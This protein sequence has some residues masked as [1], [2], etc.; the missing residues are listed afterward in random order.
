MRRYLSPRTPYLSPHAK[1]EFEMKTVCL[2]GS[3][4]TDGNS[5]AIAGRFCETAE[6]LGSEVQTFV[7]NKLTYKGCQACKGC[8]TKSDRCILKDGLTEVLDAVRETDVLVLA[9]PIYFCEITS[10][11][12]GFIDRTYSYIGADHK[13][14]L[15]PGK[16]LVFIQTQGDPD[17]SHFTDIFPRYQPAFEW[18]GFKESYLIRACGVMEKGE[19]EKREDVM[20]L[21]EDTAHSVIA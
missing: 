11:L 9:T 1:G 21:A 6:K 12:K 10:Q 2:L 15:S 16:K 13:T 7:L 14:R 3:P 4:R 20:K 18:N 17:E 8:K 5:A 19:A